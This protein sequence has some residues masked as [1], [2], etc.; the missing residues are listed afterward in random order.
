MKIVVV[1][2]DG[3]AD[4]PIPELDGLTPLEY[5]Y[6]PHVHLLARRGVTGLVRTC[7]PGLPVESAVANLGILGFDPRAAYPGGRASFEALAR[8]ISLKDGDLAL[9]CNLISIDGQRRIADFTSGTISDGEALRIIGG[10]STDGTRFE[11]YSGQS[12]RNILIVRNSPAR[13]RDLVA[14][15][16]HQH[17]GERLDDLLVQGTTPAARQLALELNSFLVGTIDQLRELNRQFHTRADMCWVWSPSER[18]GLASFEVATGLSGAV[19]CGIDTIRGIGI[20][21]RM[22]CEQIPGATGYSDSNLSAKCDYALRYLE[23]HDF[24]YIHINAPDEESHQHS[25]EGKVSS[26][27]RMDREVVGPLVDRLRSGHR[28]GYR[29]AVMPDHYTLLSSGKHKPFLVPV[30]ACGAGLAADGVRA[31]SERE[32]RRNGSIR[33]DSIRLI[34]FLKGA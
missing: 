2:G 27:E 10:L 13:A 12:Y 26:L 16:P 21:A 28:D 32:I 8:G 7:Y 18:P 30:V 25:V 31:F 15:P 9:R 23:N 14:A 33:L 4:F 3:M 22:F 11:L 29:I 17:L 6:A 1:I 5:A 20:A 34:G 24:V 19:V